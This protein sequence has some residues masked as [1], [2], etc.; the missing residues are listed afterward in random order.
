DAMD[1]KLI[2]WHKKLDPFKGRG[3][4]AYHDSWP[5][6][7]KEFGLKIDLFLE[8][9]PGVPPTPAH[10]A[11]LVLKMK[12]ERATA[13]LIEPYFNRQTAE[14][15]ARKTNAWIVDVTQFPGGIKGTDGG[16]IQLLDALVN[17]LAQ[18]LTGFT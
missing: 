3:I 7:A 14:S 17:K 12:Q 15:V 18:A 6:F 2:E 13:V 8:P 1:A 9:R 4:V 11:D 5:Y 10:L 16:Y